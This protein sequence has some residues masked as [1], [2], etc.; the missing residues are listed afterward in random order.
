VL[1]ALTQETQNS[2]LTER[3][4]VLSFWTTRR[5]EYRVRPE[6]TGL[7]PFVRSGYGGDNMRE[8]GNNISRIIARVTCFR[9][10]YDWVPINKGKANPLCKNGC[11]HP[12]C[13]QATIRALTQLSLAAG[14]DLSPPRMPQTQGLPTTLPLALYYGLERL[15]R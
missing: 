7:L 6:E 4:R 2:H 3:D 10:F 5:S 12:P 9:I 13:S 8:H 1:A 15:R 11:Y 14:T